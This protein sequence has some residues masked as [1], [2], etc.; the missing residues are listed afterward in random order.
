M[1]QLSIYSL[2]LTLT[3]AFVA[4]GANLCSGKIGQ[5][6]YSLE[7]LAHATG[8]QDAITTDQNG[9]TYYYRPCM[10][11]ANQRCKEDGASGVCQ[12]DNRFASFICF[13]S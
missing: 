12:K 11:V 3:F 5:S 9:N 8:Y 13:Y 2:A 1:R 10:A 7:G 4:H 6:F